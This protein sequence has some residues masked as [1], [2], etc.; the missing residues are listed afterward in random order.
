MS[1]DRLCNPSTMRPKNSKDEGK[2]RKDTYQS[3]VTEYIDADLLKLQNTQ[4]SNKESI[5]EYVCR[6]NSLVKELFD[7]VH[8]MFESEKLKSLLCRLHKYFAVAA[9]V[10]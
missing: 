4:I 9:K 6:P 1:I 10:I 5:V 7:V 8:S 3:T 2:K